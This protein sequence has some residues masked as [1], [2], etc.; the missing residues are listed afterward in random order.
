VKTTPLSE[1]TQKIEFMGI[2][3]TG[4][5]ITVTGITIDRLAEGKLEET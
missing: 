5:Q 1:R 2:P 4:K 3:P